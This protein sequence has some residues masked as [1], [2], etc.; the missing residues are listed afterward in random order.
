MTGEGALAHRTERPNEVVDVAINAP[1]RHWPKVSPRRWR[2]VTLFGARSWRDTG[3]VV[4]RLLPPVMPLTVSG[5]QPRP[6]ALVTECGSGGC[7]IVRHLAGSGCPDCGSPNAR[8]PRQAR[9][10]RGG[11]ARRRRVRR[12]R[13]GSSPGE[14]AP[15]GSAVIRLLGPLELERTA[16]ELITETAS[17]PQRTSVV[18]KRCRRRLLGAKP[19][20][21]R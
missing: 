8:V 12:H 6:R 2:A 20:E 4:Y 14:A 18:G 7:V 5:M 19:G 13:A 9:P 10:R 1:G 21:T 3:R 17:H 15:S 16:I 11:K